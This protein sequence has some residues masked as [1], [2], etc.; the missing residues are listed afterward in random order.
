MFGGT[1]NDTLQ[2]GLGNDILNGG[3]GNDI[4]L[5]NTAICVGNVDTIQGFSVVND[6]I[7]LE[8]SIFTSVGAAGA[9]TAT[10]FKSSGPQDADDFILY[11]TAT[12]ALSY[13]IGE[14]LT[15][16][17]AIVQDVVR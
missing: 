11:N 4:I 12:G 16:T 15:P 7:R 17:E 1:G 3:T 5:F 10:M 13:L 2:G 6:T 9:L 8:N 14:N